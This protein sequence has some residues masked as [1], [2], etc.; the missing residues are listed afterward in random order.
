[1]LRGDTELVIGIGTRTWAAFVAPEALILG[2]SSLL[3]YPV[4]ATSLLSQVLPGASRKA[5][6]RCRLRPRERMPPPVMTQGVV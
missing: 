3:V 1:M 5:L 4:R 6:E 2:A